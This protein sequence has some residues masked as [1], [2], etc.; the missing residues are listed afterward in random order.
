MSSVVPTASCIARAA[1]CF[2]RARSRDAR[3]RDLV[4]DPEAA[5][6]TRTPHP[7][8]GRRTGRDLSSEPGWTGRARARRSD[9]SLQSPPAISLPLRV[10]HRPRSP[11]AQRTFRR[12]EDGTAD[13]FSRPAPRTIPDPDSLFDRLPRSGLNE[14][15]SLRTTRM[16]SREGFR[17]H[18]DEERWDTNSSRFIVPEVVLSTPSTAPHRTKSISAGLVSRPDQNRRPRSH[19]P[20]RRGDRCS[21]RRP[22][23][24]T[25]TDGKICTRE[26]GIRRDSREGPAV[27][28]TGDESNI[29][30]AVL[31]AK[32]EL[33]RSAARKCGEM[34]K[35]V[36]AARAEARKI[37]VEPRAVKLL[38]RRRVVL[39]VG[40]RCRAWSIVSVSF[41]EDATE[42]P[43]SIAMLSPARSV[44][45][46]DERTS[47]FA[48]VSVRHPSN[49]VVPPTV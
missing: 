2:T 4:V 33:D 48:A 30:T 18:S 36:K 16:W 28:C 26:A 35:D 13:S 22:K 45:S 40:P 19:P 43:L 8:Q 32:I 41:A 20:T 11:V 25:R 31:E 5:S 24:S 3:L 46:P 23:P 42:N 47:T 12:L 14:S 38:R 34:I 29:G 9:L 10:R 21:N 7:A 44:T 37:D 6:K 49:E 39:N 27:A 17:Y 1:E 15:E